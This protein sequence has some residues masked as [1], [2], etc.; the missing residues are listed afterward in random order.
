VLYEMVTGALP[1]DS[2]SDF[3]L[4]R[5]HAEQ[6][7]RPFPRG[8]ASDA[9]RGGDLPVALE[10]I[11]LR[12]LEKQP[13]RRYADARAFYDALAA[14]LGDAPRAVDTA[15]RRRV[16]LAAAGR[17]AR[18]A[19]AVARDRA[20][21]AL[22]WLALPAWGDWP[23]WQR[24]ARANLGLASAAAVG[25]GALVLVL[26]VSAQRVCCSAPVTLAEPA[27]ANTGGPAPAGLDK[28]E[29]PV[30]VPPP[31]REPSP[32]QVVSTEPPVREARPRTTEPVAAPVSPAVT[33]PVTRPVRVNRE[34]PTPP[35][36]TPPDGPG[37]YVK[38]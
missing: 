19:H 12:A 33:P 2:V 32:V 16:D 6:V 38:R 34:R 11:I 7:P 18:H 10:H 24:W 28:V 4:M 17:H 27:S 3:A 5:A 14:V 31:A 21:A 30:D 25:A 22:R 35:P 8:G 20:A 23:A 36:S 13:E 15:R 37:W 1:F 9:A 29:P 26:A